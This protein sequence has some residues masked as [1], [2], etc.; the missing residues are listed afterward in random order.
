MI[1]ALIVGIA[2]MFIG[3]VLRP[4]PKAAKPAEMTEMESPTAE[5]GKPIGVVFGEILIKSPNF[6]WFGD[7]RYIK[8]TEKTK[9]K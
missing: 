2:L 3:Y 1:G 7:K 4:H 8:H 5:A 9:K 6:L